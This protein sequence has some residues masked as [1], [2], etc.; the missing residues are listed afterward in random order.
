MFFFF[1]SWKIAFE[2]ILFWYLEFFCCWK[3]LF[4]EYFFRFLAIYAST[5]HIED[6]LVLFFAQNS[7]LIYHHD[8]RRQSSLFKPLLHH[9]SLLIYYLSSIDGLC[10]T[11][12]KY[13][14]TSENYDIRVKATINDL[15][16][17]EKLG[18]VNGDYSKTYS[19]IEVEYWCWVNLHFKVV[20]HPHLSIDLSNFLLDTHCF[21]SNTWFWAYGWYFILYRWKE[22]KFG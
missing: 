20:F 5:W 15:E 1:H 6:L 22:S 17:K 11:I 2:F 4:F 7:L 16:A 10:M 3:R 12:T 18:F 8:E 13:T 9:D 14:L 21:H 19:K